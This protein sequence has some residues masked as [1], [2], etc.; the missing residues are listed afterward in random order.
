MQA[1][2]ASARE[3]LALVLSVVRPRSPPGPDPG[4]PPVHPDRRPEDPRRPL[5]PVRVAASGPERHRADRRGRGERAA[6]A[7]HP[8]PVALAL[9]RLGLAAGIPAGGRGANGGVRYFVRGP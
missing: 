6:T 2:D 5:P 3:A 1:H 8:G 7:R 9:G 4:P